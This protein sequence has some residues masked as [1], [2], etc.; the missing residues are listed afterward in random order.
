MKR[1]EMNERERPRE[2]EMNEKERP[3]ESEGE[4]NCKRN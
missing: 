2:R 1:K 4:T 3:R